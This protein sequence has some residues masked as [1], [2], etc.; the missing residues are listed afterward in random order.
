MQWCIS[1][2]DL[3]AAQ[4]NYSKRA[5]HL[6]TPGERFAMPHNGEFSGRACKSGIIGNTILWFDH[7]KLV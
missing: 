1:A 5:I 4:Q 6:N 3:R 2:V 7:C